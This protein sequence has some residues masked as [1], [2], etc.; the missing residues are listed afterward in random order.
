MGW[1]L[2]DRH[3][4][5]PSW[6]GPGGGPLTCRRDSLQ[7]GESWSDPGDHCV[8]HEC[9]QH[10]DGL[11]VVTTKK[12][13]PPLNCP[14][15]SPSSP[16]AL[17][18][19]PTVAVEDQSLDRSG[20]PRSAGGGAWLRPPGT[21]SPLMAPW[22]TQDKAL[23]SEDGCCLF[24]P[25]HNREWAALPGRGRGFPPAPATADL[26]TPPDPPQGR[27]VRCTTSFRSSGSRAAAPPGPC[28]SPTAGATAG[29]PPPRT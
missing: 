25:P 22:S 19:G 1:G 11:V 20:R 23:P 14:A 5:R 26:C 4:A 18:G 17:P 27:P 6:R 8:T 13:C 29:T 7:P 21:R 2:T 28:A 9:E 12:A 10:R 15:V 16:P 3:S 24:C